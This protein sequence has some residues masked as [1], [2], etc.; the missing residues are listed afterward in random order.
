METAIW[1]LCK[2]LSSVCNSVQS[3]SSS[4][5]DS[6]KRP[7]IPLESS[8][9]AFLK[10]LDR[11]ISSTSGDLNQL[12]SMAFGTVSFEELLGHCNEVYKLNQKYISDVEDRMTDFGYVPEIEMDLKEDFKFESPDR[13]ERSDLNF[14]SVSVARSRRRFLNDDALFEESVSLKN[15]GLS[16]AC[17]ATLSSKGDSF[18]P[19]PKFSQQLVS[20]DEEQ[21]NNTVTMPQESK[22]SLK[23]SGIN[24]SEANY[25]NL[26]AYM[27]SLATWEELQEA[28]IKLNLFF[29]N[30][31]EKAMFSQEDS[32]KIGLGRKG[33]SYLLI[34]LRLNQL[35]MESIDGT[36]HYKLNVAN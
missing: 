34:F 1:A 12:E 30:G 13:V 3:A 27:K 5:S 23:S 31:N 6:I 33:R 28:I 24:I 21:S 19:S 11:R 7:P 14:G 8:A 2:S 32:E 22:P 17:L 20:L 15:L 18:L 16:D 35:V 36:N 29:S 9:S 10:S 4:L 26:P 25:D